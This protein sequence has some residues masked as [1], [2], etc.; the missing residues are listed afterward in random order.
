MQYEIDFTIGGSRR[1][2][3]SKNGFLG[4]GARSLK[5]GDQIWIIAGKSTPAILRSL[6]NR[7]FKFVGEIYVHGTMH[8]EG[9]ELGLER[10]AITLE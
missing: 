2:F 8:R 3:R 6:E 9:L 4:V 10:R 5:V 1:L 7:Y